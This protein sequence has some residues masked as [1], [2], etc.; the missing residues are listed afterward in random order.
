M[1]PAARATT[2]R[3]ENGERY[4]ALDGIIFKIRARRVRS[5]PDRIRPDCSPDCL[6]DHCRHGI[7]GQQHCRRLQLHRIAAGQ[8]DSFKLASFSAEECGKDVAR[9]GGRQHLAADRHPSRYLLAAHTLRSRCIE[10]QEKS[11]ALAGCRSGAFLSGSTDDRA[12]ANRHLVGAR[13]RRAGIG[14]RQR[15]NVLQRRVSRVSGWASSSR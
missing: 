10:R 1:D 7:A 3:H 11:P 13:M 9:P 8:R 15:W 12:R 2:L 6:D 14:C 5:G 4:A